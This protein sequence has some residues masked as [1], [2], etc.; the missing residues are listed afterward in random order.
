M[1]PPKAFAPA[2]MR[3]VPLSLAVMPVRLL[4]LPVPVPPCFPGIERPSLTTAPP[5]AKN[6]PAAFTNVA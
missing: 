6:D 3:Q 2:L 4:Y 5:L 1:A